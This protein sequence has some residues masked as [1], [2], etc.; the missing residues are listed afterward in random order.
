MRYLL[1]ILVPPLAVMKCHKPRQA[2]L[3]VVLTLL[4]WLPGAA[5]AALMVYDHQEEQRAQNV[6]D[7][8][9]KW[10]KRASI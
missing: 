1:A 5:H 3:N 10:T 2:A 9:Q 6:S 4:F 7:A 8:I